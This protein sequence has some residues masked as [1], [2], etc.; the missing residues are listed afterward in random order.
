LY[1][2]RFFSTSP[3]FSFIF[4]LNFFACDNVFSKQF[5]LLNEYIQIKNQN[6]SET[7]RQQSPQITC[8]AQTEKKEKK[9]KG[10]D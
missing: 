5:A 3:C 1:F 9:R 6:E 7:I 2:T 8:I 10:R 4:S